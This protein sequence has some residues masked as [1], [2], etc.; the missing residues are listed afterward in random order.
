MEGRPRAQTGAVEAATA[1]LGRGGVVSVGALGPG[2]E[3]PDSQGTDDPGESS[4][5]RLRGVSGASWISKAVLGYLDTQA[6][7]CWVIGG[8]RNF[9]KRRV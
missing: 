5:R 6:R 1:L 8:K 2:T 7:L 3:S 9:W 4:G